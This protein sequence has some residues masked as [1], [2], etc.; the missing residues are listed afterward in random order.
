MPGNI[1]VK[2]DQHITLK[3]LL[4][5]ILAIIMMGMLMGCGRIIE[6]PIEC[7]EEVDYQEVHTP[8]EFCPAFDLELRKRPVTLEEDIENMRVDD[9]AAEAVNFCRAIESDYIL[10]RSFYEELSEDEPLIP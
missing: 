8:I 5:G 9:M 4:A 2:E 3:F 1:S 10:Y 6:V 7:P